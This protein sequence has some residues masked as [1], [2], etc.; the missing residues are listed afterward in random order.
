MGLASPSLKV[1]G[2]SMGRLFGH[3]Q[4]RVAAE[5]RGTVDSETDG[6][7][8]PPGSAYHVNCG[9]RGKA[10]CLRRRAETRFSD[11]GHARLRSHII[12][13]GW[14]IGPVSQVGRLLSSRRI[15]GRCPRRARRD[16]ADGRV[17]RVESSRRSQP[18][19]LILALRESPQGHRSIRRPD[20]FFEADG[21]A[22]T[23]VRKV[24]RRLG[25]S[26]RYPF[27]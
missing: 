15:L 1:A 17:V 9:P 16:A 11:D 13:L 26:D 27:D 10:D 19:G 2:R 22:L 8:R 18:R 21:V 20:H 12:V 4:R 14:E 24:D 25:R 3:G 7:G 6:P 23:H 5:P